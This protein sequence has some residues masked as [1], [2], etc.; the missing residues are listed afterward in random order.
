V[1]HDREARTREERPFSGF[2]SQRRSQGRGKKEEPEDRNKKDRGTKNEREGHESG[3]QEPEKETGG[4][5]S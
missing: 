5:G 3:G 2:I 1:P 4:N